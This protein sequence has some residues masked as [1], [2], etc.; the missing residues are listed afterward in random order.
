LYLLSVVLLALALD[1]WALLLM[2]AL[3]AMAWNFF[4]VPPILTFR[5]ETLHDAMMFAM[6]FV[7]AVLMG[8]ITHQLRTRET[9]ER[10]RRERALALN[11]LLESI[12]ASTTLADGLGRA[13]AEVDALFK[14]RSV[15]LLAGPDGR[16]DAT[17]H[18]ASTFQPS[19]KQVGVAAWAF[20]REQVAGRF[21]D[22]LPDATSIYIPLQTSKGKLGVLGVNMEQRKTLTLDER[23]LLETFAVQIAVLIERYRLIEAEQQALITSESERLYRTLLDSVSHELKTPLAIIETATEGLMAQSP[24]GKM[25]LDEIRRAN[26]RLRITVSNLLDMTRIEAGRLPLNLEW[27]DVADLF[28][29]ATERVKNEVATERVEISVPPDLPHVRLDFLLMEQALANLL[30][31]AAAYS[32]PGSPIRIS[33][34]MDDGTLVLRVRDQGMGL[35]PGEEK[36]VFQKFYRGPKAKAGGTGLGLSIV[37]GFVHAHGGEVSGENNPTSGATFTIRL[38]VETGKVPA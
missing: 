23:E 25:F 26:Y 17:A 28:Q 5:I 13:V 2:A 18:P 11:R 30:T 35:T 16:L 15:V 19:V 37:Q 4:F 1:R 36:K 9:A 22:T 3:S 24:H 20:E 34:E 6:Y 10:K 21:T 38:P 12:A 33:A 32:P 7:V 14:S 8:H 27:F 31:N 29:S